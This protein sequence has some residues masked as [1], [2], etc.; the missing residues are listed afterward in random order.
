MLID[1]SPQVLSDSADLDEDLV[2]D[3]HFDRVL[4]SL[5]GSQTDYWGDPQRSQHNEI[6]HEDG[7][8]HSTSSTRAGTWSS[9]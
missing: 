9:C 2:E 1:R 4:A 7:A 3:E 8:A 5:V 6:R